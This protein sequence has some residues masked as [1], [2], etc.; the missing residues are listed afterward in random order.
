MAADTSADPSNFIDILT[1]AFDGG[2]REGCLGAENIGRRAIA[3][4]SRRLVKIIDAELK[5]TRSPAPGCHPDVVGCP[6]AQLADEGL[7][8]IG[9]EP[10]GD[11][12]YL[13]QGVATTGVN[14][15][16]GPCEGATGRKRRISDYGYVDIRSAR[17]E[18]E[19]YIANISLVREAGWAGNRGERC[20]LV[21]VR[22][23]CRAKVDDLCQ[24]N[25]SAALIVLYNL[26]CDLCRPTQDRPTEQGREPSVRPSR[27]DG[28]P[29]SSFLHRVRFA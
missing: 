7:D 29:I 18:G 25:G 1:F 27:L 12:G 22:P 9:A 23:R 26:R 28:H 4:G 6:D 20:I 16:L 5:S 21:A 10:I 17:D 8:N 15:K 3:G 13:C 2:Y 14:G 19:P 24:S 11:T